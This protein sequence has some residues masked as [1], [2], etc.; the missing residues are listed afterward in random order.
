MNKIPII[1]YDGDEKGKFA[2]Q[3]AANLFIENDMYCKVVNLPEGFDLAD[4]SMQ[5]EDKLVKYID[6]NTYTY[7]Y[8]KI[9]ELIK[10]YNKK[11]YELQLDYSLEAKK[12]LSKIPDN[13]KDVLEGYLKYSLGILKED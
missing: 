13:E 9:N 2:T 6:D 12:I 10:D 5:L 1:I 11:L 3:K 7:G 8:S 4:I